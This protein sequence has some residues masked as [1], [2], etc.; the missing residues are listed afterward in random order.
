MKKIKALIFI[1]FL[2]TFNIKTSYAAIKIMPDEISIG[3]NYSQYLKSYNASSNNITWQSSNPNVVTVDNGRITGINIGEAYVKVTDGNTLALCKVKVIDNYV[4]ITSISLEQNEIT[5]IVNNTAKI[6]PIILP[7]NASNKNPV[8]VSSSEDIATVNSSGYVTAKKIGKT[9]IS[10]SLEN[11][12]AIYKVTVV[13][14]IPL[15]S[16][17]I[18]ASVE[19]KQNKSTKLS[20]TYFPQ[21]ATDKKVTWQSSNPNIVVVDNNGNIKGMTPGNATIT[22]TSND[23]NHVATS[24][25]TVIA[26][27]PNVTNNNQPQTTKKVNPPSSTSATN[28]DNIVKLNSISLDKKN[29]TLNIN[30]SRILSVTYNPQNATDKTV[31]WKSSNS[32]IVKVDNNGKL[33]ALA[34]GIATITVTSNDGK[35]EAKCN[36]TVNA[37]NQQTTDKK[38][39]NIKLN[40]NKLKLKKGKEVTLEV[41]YTPSDADNKELS[42]ISS[43]EDVATVKNGKITALAVGTTEIKVISVDGNYEDKCYV[44]VYSDLPIES[45]VFEKEKQTVYIGNTI[46]LNTISTPENTIIENPIWTSSNESIATVND[47]VVTGNTVG[48]TTITISDE[49]GEITASTTVY[50]IE[51]PLEKLSITIEGYDL[52]F[53]PDVKN[54]TLNIG[55]E[56]ELT[57]KTNYDQSRVTIGGNR[58]LKNGSI[59]TIT[60]IDNKNVKTTYVINVKKKSFNLIYFIAIISVLLIAN[61]IRL[62]INTKKK[63]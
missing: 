42:W 8:Y 11:K 5:L 15:E 62:L 31:T 57:I 21:N 43:N 48:K 17:T 23:G 4:P 55:T 25:V 44:T 38:L 35:H 12:V 56:S 51:K 60:V 63:K 50:V 7:I 3:I 33:T 18:D 16:I 1:I 36:I 37:N 28:N 52:K 19:L 47:G 45:I 2:M 27:T 26:N 41:T 13:D 61:L 54:Y 40:E 10:V 30:E 32:N 49:L 29:I 46:T 9:N 6:N 20:V 34:E 58:D 24:K 53:D 22:V 39:R 14:K 59:I